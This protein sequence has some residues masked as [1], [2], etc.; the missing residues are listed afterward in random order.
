MKSAVSLIL[1]LC[2]SHHSEYFVGGA[3]TEQFKQQNVRVEPDGVFVEDRK[4][5]DLGQI[6]QTTARADVLEISEARQRLSTRAS[7]G[8]WVG[9]GAAIAGATVLFWFLRICGGF[10]CGN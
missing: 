3:K 2:P 7:I 8:K 4:V 5:A 1:V 10:Q 9:I 6:V